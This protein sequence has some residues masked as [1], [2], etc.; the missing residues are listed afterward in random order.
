MKGIMN[1]SAKTQMSLVSKSKQTGLVLFFALI[2]LVAMSLAAAALVRS[3]DT[4]V[5]VAGNLAFKQSATMS[6]ESGVTAAYDFFNNVAKA[7]SASFLQTKQSTYGYVANM[8]ALKT[9]NLKLT[10]DTVWT[11]T[12]SRLA[13]GNGNDANGKDASGN[14][15][16]YIV[17]RMCKNDGASNDDDCMVGTVGAAESGDGGGGYKIAGGF[18]SGSNAPIYRVTTRVTGPKN[19]VSYVQAYIY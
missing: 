1:I 14:T 16:R 5:L 12:W 6:A 8:N 10:S 18:R 13:T 17:E 9:A 4:S 19:T 15:V 7:R 3:V 2:A 11:D